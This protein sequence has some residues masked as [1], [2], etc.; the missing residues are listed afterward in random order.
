MYRAGFDASK[1]RN[2]ENMFPLA[3]EVV[4]PL[5]P[6]CILMTSTSLGDCESYAPF[7]T[8]LVG[9]VTFWGNVSG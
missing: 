5:F 2:C 8:F 7:C 9:G 6:I 3:Y 4:E 1:E